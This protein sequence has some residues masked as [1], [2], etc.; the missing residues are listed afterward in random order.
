[1]IVF[2]NKVDLL[3]KKLKAGIKF[4]DHLPSYGTRPNEPE[5]VIKCAYVISSKTTPLLKPSN[6][7]I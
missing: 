2:I 1:M 3:V 5:A 6:R 7:Y 4:T